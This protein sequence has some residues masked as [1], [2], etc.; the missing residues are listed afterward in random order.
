V[1]EKALKFN[2]QD[3]L[4]N[5]LI[6]SYYLFLNFLDGKNG[7]CLFMKGN[8]RSSKPALPETPAHNKVLQSEFPLPITLPLPILTRNL[9]AFPLL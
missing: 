1:I 3:E 2:F 6:K 4:V 9:Q 5:E 8:I 7:T